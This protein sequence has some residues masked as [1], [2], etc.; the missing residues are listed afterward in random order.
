MLCQFP[1][2]PSY[3]Y[4]VYEALAFASSAAPLAFPDSSLALPLAS[5]LNSEAFPFACPRAS[6]ALALTSEASVP[7]VSLV[8]CA[9]FS[10]TMNQYISSKKSP[11]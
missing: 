10:V 8:F 6:L 5:P 7:T 1:T 2:I 3:H 11:A 4:Q 9:T